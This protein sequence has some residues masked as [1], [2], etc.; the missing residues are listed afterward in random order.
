MEDGSIVLDGDVEDWGPDY[1]E[2]VRDIYKALEKWDVGKKH[3]FDAVEKNREDAYESDVLLVAK[4]LARHEKG[5]KEQELAL[6]LFST[7]DWLSWEDSLIYAELL[8]EGSPEEACKIIHTALEDE[9]DDAFCL[10]EIVKL[11][12]HENPVMVNQAHKELIQM[13]KGGYLDAL[14][15][16]GYS[17]YY[18]KSGFEKDWSKAY[19]WWKKSADKGN[20]YS[21]LEVALMYEHAQGTRRNRNKA[22]HYTKMAADKGYLRALTNLGYC[23]YWGIGT[24]KDVSAVVDCFQRVLDKENCEVAS[25]NLAERYYAGEGVVQNYAQAIYLHQKAARKGY[26]DSITRLGYMRI[27]GEGFPKNEKLGVSYLRKAI[28][29]GG[30]RALCELGKCYEYGTGVPKNWKKAMELYEQSAEAG[31]KHTRSEISRLKR[32][33]LKAEK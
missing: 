10:D 27:H 1:D 19:K 6:Y 17:Y 3:V 28:K 13:A 32:K 16:L 25:H 22:F 9:W 2:V 30:A 4:E 21:M 5:T 20:E 23:Y 8:L 12:D 24:K 18:G 29:L 7:S 11:C 14:H 31:Y 33:M 26:P 15:R